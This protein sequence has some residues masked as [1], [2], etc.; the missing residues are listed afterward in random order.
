MIPV[1]RHSHVC[2]GF[3]TLLPA[4]RG[5]AQ[6]LDSTHRLGRHVRLVR[7]VQGHNPSL[8]SIPAWQY[9]Y[10]YWGMY[11][12]IGKVHAGVETPAACVSRP[13]MYLFALAHTLHAHLFGRSWPSQL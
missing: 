3:N 6:A 9:L 2:P 4:E 7:K 5:D 8:S 10:V 12:V 13:V 1:S 11:E